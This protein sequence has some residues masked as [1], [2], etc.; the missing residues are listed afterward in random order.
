MYSLVVGAGT[1]A[2]SGC[3]SGL[4]ERLSWYDKRILAQTVKELTQLGR[5]RLSVGTGIAVN[6]AAA[7]WL[8]GVAGCQQN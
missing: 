6:P 4:E 2:R 7:V 5:D 3:A 8:C 1:A